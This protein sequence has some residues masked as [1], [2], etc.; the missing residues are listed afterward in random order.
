MSIFDELIGG[1]DRALRTLTNTH[2]AARRN[3]GEEVAEVDLSDEERAHAAGLMRV[4]YTGEICAQALYEGQA[5]TAR[6]STVRNRLLTA[7]EKE[8]DHLAWCSERLDELDSRPSV[9]NPL[10]YAA[11]YALGV[12]TGLAGDKISL[13]M[14]EA[15]EDRVCAHLENHLDALPATDE[16][17]RAIVTQMYEDEARHGAE[18]LAAGGE[19]FPERVKEIMAVMSRLMTE[20]T[21]RV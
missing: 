18:A 9:L 12:A 21:Y 13:G 1:F 14:V 16:R 6:D 5:A 15:T 7:A 4:N 17:S 20:T 8:A 11:S 10:F 19:E 2:E 3:P